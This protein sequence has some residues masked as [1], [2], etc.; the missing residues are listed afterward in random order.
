MQECHKHFERLHNMT[1]GSIVA[2][3]LV[4]PTDM[5][6]ATGGE[7]Q[8]KG[9]LIKYHLEVRLSFDKDTSMHVI[10][11][12]SLTFYFQPLLIYTQV[13]RD[14]QKL[15]EAR[16]GMIINKISTPSASF[17]HAW[18]EFRERLARLGALKR[19]TPSQFS[20]L[21]TWAYNNQ[22][23]LVVVVDEPHI[24]E[25]QDQEHHKERKGNDTEK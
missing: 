15:S 17:L 5:S 18:E 25:P 11:P 23:D 3:Q 10:S 24:Q 8:V 21:I 4:Y 13:A 9:G 20:M 22:K 1:G 2:D 14:W 12:Y 7:W 19:F 6:A 16:H